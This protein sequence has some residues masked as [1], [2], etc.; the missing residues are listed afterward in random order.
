[1]LLNQGEEYRVVLGDCI[2]EMARMPQASCDLAVFSPPF[3]QF[4][5]LHVE[6][7]GRGQQ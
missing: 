7:G 5:R 2:E 4:V 1:M 6:R 3:P